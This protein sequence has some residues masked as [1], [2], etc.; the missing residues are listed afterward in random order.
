MCL[1]VDANCFSHVFNLRDKRHPS[2]AP[3][4]DWLFY[5]NGG[6]LIYGGDKYSREVD[7]TS[8]TYL[9]LLVELHRKGRMLEMCGKC[10]NQVSA[11]KLKEIVPDN[12]DFDDE[13]IL[14]LAIIS[15]CHIICTEDMRAIPFLKRPDL[16]P[17]GISPPK[18]YQSKRNADLVRNNA[19]VAEVCRS[20]GNMCRRIHEAGP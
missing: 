13:H 10:V 2:F 9:P 12:P 1:I 20:K 7:F 6:G 5:G 19:N 11:R 17:E 14:A 18:I 16:Y 3:V 4:F 15:K 8:A